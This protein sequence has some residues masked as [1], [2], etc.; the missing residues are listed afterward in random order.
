MMIAVQCPGHT[1]DCVVQH[2]F[3][4]PAKPLQYGIHTRHH[5]CMPRGCCIAGSSS[6]AGPV[7]VGGATL[8]VVVVTAVAF[9]PC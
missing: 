6:G 7:I 5:D 1:L 3:S 4:H 9:L 2:C 8:F